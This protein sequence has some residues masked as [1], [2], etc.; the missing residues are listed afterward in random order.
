MV[1]SSVEA[2]RVL[3]VGTGPSIEKVQ[4]PS[5]PGVH[6][7]AVNHAVNWLP[8][9]DSFFSM[10]T[11]PAIM[12]LIDRPRRAVQYYHAV[13]DGWQQQRRPWVRYLRRVMGMGVRGSQDRL[14]ESPGEIHAGNSVYGAL[15]LAYHWRPKKIAFVGLDA[16]DTG[17]AYDRRKGP[18][19]SLKHLP[20]LFFSAGPQLEKAGIEVVNGSLNSKVTCFIRWAPQRAIEWIAKE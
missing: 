6:I 13:P 16:T 18:A 5:L 17:Y 15:N 11:A 12:R 20:D 4:F 3:I 2:P 8:H 7:I 1:L 19:W 10:D 9:A 14:A